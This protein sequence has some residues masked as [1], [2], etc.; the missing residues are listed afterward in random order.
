M[1]AGQVDKTIAGYVSTNAALEKELAF[2]RAAAE[3]KDDT[4]AT[5]AEQLSKLMA[6]SAVGTHA[7]EAVLEEAKKREVGGDRD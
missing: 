1:S 7:L 4:I 3:R 5:Q 6:Y 2:W